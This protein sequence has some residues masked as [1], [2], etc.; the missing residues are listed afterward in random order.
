ML[1]LCYAGVTLG[2]VLDIMLVAAE[3]EA[4][5]RQFGVWFRNVCRKIFRKPSR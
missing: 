3:R 1:P 2:L 5:E 4:H